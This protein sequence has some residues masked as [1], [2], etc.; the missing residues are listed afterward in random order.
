MS[1][2]YSYPPRAVRAGCANAAHPDQ[3]GHYRQGSVTA[4]KHHWWWKI[5]RVFDGLRVT[6]NFTG[7][8]FFF[9]ED[10]YLSTD[11][12]HVARELTRLKNE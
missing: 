4:I 2:V 7:S 10:H 12:V 6:S 8:V 5:N 11:A 1:D 3:Y 9:E